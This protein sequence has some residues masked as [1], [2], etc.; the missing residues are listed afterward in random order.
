MF[1]TQKKRIA[2]NAVKHRVTE[3]LRRSLCSCAKLRRPHHAEAQQRCLQH[4]SRGPKPFQPVPHRVYLQPKSDWHEPRSCLEPG[5]GS[6][7]RNRVLGAATFA[8]GSIISTGSPSRKKPNPA[9]NERDLPWRSSKT[10]I[11]MPPD[12]SVRMT[13][14][15]QPEE[16]SSRESCPVQWESPGGVFWVLVH[17][18]LRVGSNLPRTAFRS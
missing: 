7:A 16:T 12:F 2:D 17:S 6:G 4:V 10:M 9:W 14:P 15:T 13:S 1:I 5:H 11:R 8:T 18:D 3:K